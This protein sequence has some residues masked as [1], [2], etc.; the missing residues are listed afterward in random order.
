MTQPNALV[1]FLLRSGLAVVF[2]YAATSSFLSP[3]DWMGYFPQFM[4]D[5]VPGEILLPIFS[6]CELVL[7]L[8]LL[9]GKYPVASGIVAAAALAG[10]I[11]SNLTQLPIIFRDIAILSAALS[12][13][14]LHYKRTEPST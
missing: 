9:S 5:I 8:W 10:I 12:L 7:A 14:A 3:Q 11:V 4:R 2:L 13:S 1:S 6:V